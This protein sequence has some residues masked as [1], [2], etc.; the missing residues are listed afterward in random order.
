MIVIIAEPY[1]GFPDGTAPTSRVTAY[2]RG[3]LASGEQVRVILLGPSELDPSNAVNTEVR[4]VYRDIP[5]EYTSAS[6]LKASSL[7]TRRWAFFR[8]LVTARRRLRELASESGVDAILLYSDSVRIASFFHSVSLELGARYAVDLCEM[9]HH[10]L[11]PGRGRDDEQERYGRSF[12]PRFDL[13]IAIS[14]PLAEYAE[15]FARHDE[16]V[17]LL[18]VMVDCDEYRPRDPSGAAHGPVTYAGLLN[19]EKDGVATLMSAF[20]KVAPDFPD[21]ALRLVGDS[22]DPVRASNVPEFRELAERLGIARRVEFSGMVPRADL[23]RYLAEA[24]V[25]VLARPSSQQAEAGLPSKVG[26][27]LAAGRPVIVTRVG[28]IGEY[29]RDGESA[30]LVPPDDADALARKLA[31]VLGDPERALRV[32][33]AGRCVAEQR[34]DYRVAT[35]PLARMLVHARPHMGAD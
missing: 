20:A 18:P 27:Y 17:I 34:F 24:S 4:G 16:D 30:Y 1:I 3:L 7:I 23:P 26:E 10:R 11:P 15:R 9:P 8:S 31:E 32:G 13:V 25:L 19:E 29:L 6:T 28:D 2:A 14:R 21:V 12:I 35:A 5:F 22:Y 33:A